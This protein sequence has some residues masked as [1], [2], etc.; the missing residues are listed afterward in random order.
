MGIGLMKKPLIFYLFLISVNLC[1]IQFHPMILD[2]NSIKELSGHKHDENI[3]FISFL[4]EHNTFRIDRIVKELSSYY[5]EKIDCTACANCCSCLRPIL[6][7]HDMD[8]M[9]K[10][11]QVP[12]A[13]FR[14]EYTVTD[15]DGDTMLRN[16]PCT[17]LA[18]RKCTIYESRP[19][20]C[21]AYPHLDKKLFLERLYGIFENYAICPIVYNVIE[22]LK[23]RLK[24]PV[25]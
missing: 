3:R 20:D 5:S 15:D 19:E 4:K 13:K 10:A 1:I 8:V 9:V 25:K 6:S 24:F 12:K 2:L 22:E 14:K 7:E 23:V 16:L 17:F 11:L 18:G 21:R